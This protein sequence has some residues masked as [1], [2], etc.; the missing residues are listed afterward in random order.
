MR[1]QATVEATLAN[2]R[3]VGIA[4][5]ILITPSLKIGSAGPLVE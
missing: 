2:K 5:N 4:G 3:L 1:S